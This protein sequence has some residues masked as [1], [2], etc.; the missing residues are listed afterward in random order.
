MPW[1]LAGLLL[2]TL[3]GLGWQGRRA[4]RLEA[5]VATLS[6]ELAGARSALAAHEVHLGRIRGS[7]A[8]LLLRLGALDALV[9]GDPAVAAPNAPPADAEAPPVE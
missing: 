5:R 4:A 7:V 2:L 3:A 8:D 1:L 9:Q 6:A